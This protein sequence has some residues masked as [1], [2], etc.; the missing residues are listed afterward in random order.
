[1]MPSVSSPPQHTQVTARLTIVSA[2]DQA[3]WRCLYQFLRNAERLDL[4]SQYQFVAY[5]LGLDARSR[6]FLQSRFPWCE[7]RRFAFEQYPPHIGRDLATFAWKP[8]LLHEVLSAAKSP[9]LW[10]DSATLIRQPLDGVIADIRRFGVYSLRGQSTLRESCD[11]DILD[12]LKVPDEMRERPIHVGGVLGFDADNPT[13]QKLVAVWRKHH[14]VAD[15]VRKATARH[16]ADQALLSTVMLPMEAIGDLKLNDSEVD[17]S[18]FRPVRWMTSRNKA[19]AWLPLWL[20]PAVRLYYAVYKRL[21]QINLK[22]R[23]KFNE[24]INGI[25]RFTKEHFS[26]FVASTT[27][28]KVTKISAP[29]LSYYA[30]PFIWRHQGQDFL[31]CEEFSYLHHKGYLRFIP[32]DTNLHPGTARRLILSRDHASFPFLFEDRDALYLVPET[33]AEGGVH[34][35][36]CD[37]FPEQWTRVRTLLPALDAVD[38]VIF[39]HDG[40]WWL[41][42]SIRVRRGSAARYLAVF[43]SEDLMATKWHAHPVNAQKLYCDLPFSSG[44]NAGA[45][46]HASD[47]LLRPT[48]HNLSYYGAQIRWM[49]ITQLTTME[50]R[51]CPLAAAYPLAELST[52]LSMHHLTVHGDLIAWDVR[53]RVGLMRRLPIKAKD[54]LRLPGTGLGRAFMDAVADL[55]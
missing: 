33:S 30:D 36:R 43:F 9:V 17:I 52:K 8:L 41:I 39:R 5:D 37:A 13:A 48:Q 32:L 27:D 46:V 18:S 51:E 54:S 42:T 22:M 7:F 6:Q 19:P 20:D 44:R 12:A 11:S 4:P 53:D 50:Y 10:L 49:E 1:M 23:F 24:L 31:L 14:L 35:Y 25:L 40:L 38:T 45:V 28:R 55:S 26:V 34:L 21:D 29:I 2:A 15:F 47:R 16:K 3:Y